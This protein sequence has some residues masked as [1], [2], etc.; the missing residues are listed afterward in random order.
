MKKYTIEFDTAE[1]AK[2]IGVC[3]AALVSEEETLRCLNG[4]SSDNT[5][6]HTK[7]SIDKIWEL[8]TKLKRAVFGV[9]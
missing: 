6:K 8:K 9:K 7:N 2:L 3:N 5:I 1:I 4:S